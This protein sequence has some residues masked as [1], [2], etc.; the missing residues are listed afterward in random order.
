M[1]IK[2]ALQCSVMLVAVA[3]TLPAFAQ[4]APQSDEG[5]SII[6]TG[7]R[8]RQ[9]PL[10]QDSPVIT[11]DQ[12]ALARTG[13]SAVA[14]VLQ[15]LPSASGGLNSKAN[16][17]GNIGN[18]PDGGGV[19][20]GSAEIDL[21]Y[22]GSKRTLVLVDG[23]RYV[24]GSSASGIPA[25]VDLNTIPANMIERIEVL[26][27]GQSPLYGSDALA[28]VVNI[29]TKASQEGLQA[30]AQFGT[31][32][33]GDGHTQDYQLSYGIKAPTTNIVFGVSYVKQDAVSTRDRRI[34]QFPNPGQTSCS[35]SIGGCSSA[36]VNG[37]I[38][39]GNGT[40][41][42][43]PKN[44]PLSGRGRYDPL[45]PTGPNSDFRAF[46][47]DDRFN[48]S[49]YNYFLTPSERYGGFISAKQ[50][51][52]DNINFRA[53]LVYNR[54]NSQNQAAFLPLFVG[55]DAGNGNLLDTI[56]IDATNPY[57]PFGYTLSAGGNGQ[58]PT[59]STVRR[60][61]VEAGQRTYS[62]KVDTMTMSGGFDGSFDIGS[63]KWY[64]DATAF[65]GFNDA[66]QL[67]T[68]NI[69]AAKLAQA[70]GPVANCTA[71]C[72]PF[73]IFGGAGSVTPDM[74]AFIAFDERAKSRQ[75]I[76]DYTANLSGDLFD[77]PAGP[78]GVAIGY[79]HRYQFGSYSP[80]PI[81][82][83]G[84]GADIPSLP[85]KG[86]YNS[87][88][89]YAE[90]RVP[91]LKD[92]P[93]FHSLDLDGA[94]RHANYSTS[95]SSTTFTGSVLWKPVADLLLRGSYAEGFRA[96]SI[97]ELFG[98]A[99]RSDAPID[100]PCTSAAGGLFNSNA[101][102][103]ANCIANGVPASGSYNEPTGGQLS[104]LTGGNQALKPETSKT[105][106]FGGVYSPAWVRDSGI[107]SALSLEVNYY[108]IEVNDAISNIAPQ[109]TLS[110]CALLG[111]PLACGSVVR[112]GSG[113]ISRINGVLQNIGSIKTRGIDVTFNY[114]SPNTGAGTIGLSATGNF[115]L[116]YDETFPSADG[117]TTTS[118][119]GTT[120]G[121]PDQSYPRFKGNAVIDWTM[122]SLTASFTGRYIRGVTEAD[123]KR[124]GNTFY[125]DVQISFTPAFLDRRTSFTI[126]VNNV[127]NQDPPACFS[128][129]GPNYDP[130][131]Y[132][133]P[134]Q[135]GYARIS[136]KM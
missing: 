132:D 72:V 96:P 92:T 59:Y 128:C 20:A 103:R 76:R 35:D 99:S 57:N 120:R 52:S 107:G 50:E 88:E 136:Y 129:T 114:R 40:P 49:P 27:S 104:V 41:V 75:E 81:I 63:H 105:W 19:G 86:S 56:S 48:F 66:K 115:L 9:N 131:T 5:A 68:G 93:F 74:L 32:R 6:V 89:I 26:Q 17:S 10:E 36:P 4:S 100:D 30:S 80:D 7:S 31:Y 84:L 61:L 46:T 90:L 71:P 45:N 108:D 79:E 15:R 42:L 33:Q 25:T 34:S 134:G 109:A 54:R 97:G 82:A 2:T 117:F 65:F 13:L 118:Y 101:T 133:V 98:A 102:V 38:D 29:I 85:A 116:K 55:P 14:D 60:R 8:I 119:R 126:G 43:T 47:T 69:N 127:F 78:V 121:F 70:L 58:A 18:P 112:T 106:L 91:V 113:L 94:V 3:S 123:G 77:L 124:L 62:Q 24:N 83:A 73:N 87:D 64:W 28:G 110:R 22:L 37:F 67:F 111:D 16:N 12:Q 53:K 125:G 135:F 39:L 23:M 44:P 1:R 95:G 130:T 122:E 11:V 21:R 51:L